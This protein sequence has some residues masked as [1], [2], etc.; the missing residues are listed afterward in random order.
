MMLAM[1]HRAAG[2]VG[3]AGVAA[4]VLA[5]CSAPAPEPTPSPSAIDLTVVEACAA[6]VVV[7]EDSFGANPSAD[8]PPSVSVPVGSAVSFPVPAGA[9]VGVVPGTSSGDEAQLCAAPGDEPG[10]EFY[11]ALA[12]GY[13]RIGIQTGID[14]PLRLFVKVTG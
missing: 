5:G 4:A 7:P 10:T 14:P 13:T 11:V 6:D 8:A 12:P 3:A 1:G 2:L 9:R